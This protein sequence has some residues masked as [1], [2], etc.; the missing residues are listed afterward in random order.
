MDRGK[1]VP[2]PNKDH[3]RNPPE[4][5][6]Q[7]VLR[8]SRLFPKTVPVEVNPSVFVDERFHD[9]VPLR[10]QMKAL[11]ENLVYSIAYH[12]HPGYYTG[13]NY[14]RDPRVGK[15]YARKSPNLQRSIASPL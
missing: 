7:F 14:E 6:D 9:V 15:G 2:A 12:P 11:R 13:Y 10:Q 1:F 8:A 4:P 5:S 3:L